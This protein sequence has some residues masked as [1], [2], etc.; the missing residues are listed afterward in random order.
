MIQ[1]SD[2]V[3]SLRIFDPQYL[4]SNFNS[5]GSHQVPCLLNILAWKL[6]N[7]H[8]NHPRIDPT[9]ITYH[10]ILFFFGTTVLS[11]PHVNP[12]GFADWVSGKICRNLYLYMVFFS[13]ALKSTHWSLDLQ[14]LR[15]KAMS[16]IATCSPAPW[17]LKPR[18]SAWRP[19]CRRSLRCCSPSAW[20]LWSPAGCLC[21]RF[22]SFGPTRTLQVG[23]DLRQRCGNYASK[24]WN[25][26][27]LQGLAP[28]HC[29]QFFWECVETWTITSY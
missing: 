13:F 29:C 3:P 26:G 8:E 12:Q 23:M 19:T 2:Y 10:L 4:Y 20:F 17:V 22:K 15:T 1:C 18:P 7:K 16:Q 21:P 28:L 9:L 11:S 24:H 6:R 14:V 27:D 5:F 25:F